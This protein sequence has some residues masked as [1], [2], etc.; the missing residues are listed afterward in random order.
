MSMNGY[1]PFA[2]PD[3]FAKVEVPHGQQRV[4][5]L[6]KSDEKVVLSGT[7]GAVPATKK[8]A[9]GAFCQCGV[10]IALD[11]EREPIW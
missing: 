10:A 1:V 8:N 2:Q 9:F 6:A 7:R 4:I 11:V 3:R 5:K